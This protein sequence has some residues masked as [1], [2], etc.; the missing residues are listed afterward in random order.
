MST[1][2]FRRVRLLQLPFGNQKLLVHITRAMAANRE[3][4]APRWFL[5]GLRA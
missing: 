3:D 2:Y 5:A 1:S 4:H